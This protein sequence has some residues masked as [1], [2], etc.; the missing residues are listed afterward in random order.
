MLTNAM[1]THEG[2]I[3]LLLATM[4]EV[5]P[6]VRLSILLAPLPFSLIA[7]H[8]QVFIFLNLNGMFYCFHLINDACD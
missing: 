3:W 7:I 6:T 8:A 4:A 1:F 2:I 5:P